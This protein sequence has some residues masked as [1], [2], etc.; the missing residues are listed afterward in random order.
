MTNQLRQSL[1]QIWDDAVLMYVEPMVE[2]MRC[3][4]DLYTTK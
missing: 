3:L 2:E 1:Q 4:W